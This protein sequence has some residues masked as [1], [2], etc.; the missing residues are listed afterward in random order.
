MCPLKKGSGKKTAWE[1]SAYFDIIW[2]AVIAGWTTSVLRSCS[3]DHCA[4]QWSLYLLCCFLK[5][6]WI[7]LG[8]KNQ[9]TNQNSPY[10]TKAWDRPLSLFMAL[11]FWVLPTVHQ[12]LL[13][14]SWLPHVRNF[15]ANSVIQ[16]WVR[17]T[18]A[19]V[20][21]TQGLFANC[22]LSRLT[23]P[24]KLLPSGYRR[25]CFKYNEGWEGQ[26]PTRWALQSLLEPSDGSS[27]LDRCCCI[28]LPQSSA[29]KCWAARGG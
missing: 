6:H 2:S 24:L 29:H 25:L 13:R 9:K 21:L 18:A 14:S 12:Q 4:A 3:V 27:V 11:F 1:I 23:Q 22:T 15:G 10:S 26:E 7:P 19:H 5:N 20:Y 16:Q 17:I 8:K 28:S